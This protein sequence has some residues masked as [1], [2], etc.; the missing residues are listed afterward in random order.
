M[1]GSPVPVRSTEAPPVSI[2]GGT[3]T[4]PYARK[5]NE[6]EGAWQFRVRAMKRKATPSAPPML[7]DYAYRGEDPPAGG[8]PGRTPQELIT[9]GGFAPWQIKSS[10]EARS[11]LA[12]LCSGATTLQQRAYAWQ[13]S[14]NK[15]DGYFVS[16]GT[17]ATKAYDTYTCFYR[18]R[19]PALMRRKWNDVGLDGLNLDDVRD[20]HHFLDGTTAAVSA[21]IGVPC[22]A[23]A[24]CVCEL[25]VMTAVP[26]RAIEIKVGADWKALATQ[27]KP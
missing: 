27:K 3:P 16:T 4:D 19:I 18:T 10:D 26:V 9:Q 17:Q 22:L 24:A 1:I 11:S 23:K 21:F 6:S 25:P 5:P 8:K 13:K 12:L 15:G 14:K 7:S 20:G 2:D